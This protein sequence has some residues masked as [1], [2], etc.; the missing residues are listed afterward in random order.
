MLG[1]DGAKHV[2]GRV[3][4]ELAEGLGL[5]SDSATTRTPDDLARL[6]HKMAGSAAVVGYKQIRL[7][8]AALETGFRSAT[9]P[10]ALMRMHMAASLL[11]DRAD[12]TK[13]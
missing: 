12:W 1:S 3:H 6:A 4:D 7:D 10:E 9:T 11:R 2:V 8:L 5:L 13:L